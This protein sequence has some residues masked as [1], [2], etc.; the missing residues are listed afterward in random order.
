MIT[1]KRTLVQTNPYLKNPVRAKAMLSVA[2]LESSVFEGARLADL[3]PP[4]DGVSFKAC[5]KPFRT[6]ASKKAAKGR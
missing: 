3:Q 2:A 4:R 1:M 5:R 6:A